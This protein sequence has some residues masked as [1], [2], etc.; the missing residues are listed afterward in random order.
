M[1]TR[2]RYLAKVNPSTPEFDR[3]SPT[4]R[5]TF[6]PL[7]TL[8]ADYRLDTSRLRPKAE[9]ATGYVRFRDGDV[10]VPKVTPTFQ[11]GRSAVVMGLHNGVGAGSTELH[12]LRAYGHSDARFVR[13]ATQTIRFLSEGVAAFQGVAGLQRVPEDFVRDFEVPLMPL[14]EQRRIADFLD[15]QVTLIDRSIELR[16]RQV[17]KLL[18]LRSTRVLA[19]VT[20]AEAEQRTVGA[21]PWA[22]SVAADWPIAKISHLA[23][24]GSGHTPSRSRPDWW[25]DCTIPWIT[26]GEV[27]QLRDDRKETIFESREKISWLGVA[28][29]SAEVHPAG[30]VVLSRTASAGFSAV[31]G[32]AMA[33]SQDYVTWTCGPQLEPYYLLW[34]LRAMRPDLLGRLA[35]GSTHKTIYVPDIQSLRIPKPPIDVQRQIVDSLRRAN[36]VVDTSVDLMRRH[37][38]LLFERKQSLITATVTGQFDVTTAR[39]VA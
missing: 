4:K 3:L 16:Q 28:N 20:G 21:L 32:Q 34:C 9:V 29:S 26:T 13:Y 10:L 36:L 23:R 38:G 37:V 22:D 12:V 24:L 35:M 15:D 19:A 17:E 30:T 2:L 31:M 18:E 5:V 7:E 11:A 27:Q 6:M 33:T 39:S 8:W 1:H 14:H 25:F